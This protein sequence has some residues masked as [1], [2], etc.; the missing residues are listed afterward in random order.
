[1]FIYSY[2]KNNMSQKT[3]EQLLKIEEVT[4][5][6]NRI[7]EMKGDKIAAFDL[8]DT[9]TNKSLIPYPGVVKKLKELISECY[10]IIIFSNQKERHIGDK[11]LNTKLQQVATNLNIPFLAFC[12]RKEDQYRKPDI[13]MISLIPKEF[14]TVKFFVGD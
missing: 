13:G 5:F 12:A 9:L 3:I 11:K 4:V 1:M 7:D 10:N 2:S 14:G 8:D 6:L